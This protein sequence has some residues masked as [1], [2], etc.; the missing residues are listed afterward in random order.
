MKIAC[1]YISFPY[2]RL[3]HRITLLFVLLL[4]VGILAACPAGPPPVA[5]EPTDA[6]VAE[7]TATPETEGIACERSPLLATE[8]FGSRSEEADENQYVTFE[9]EIDSHREDGGQRTV[10]L[11]LHQSLVDEALLP[12]EICPLTREGEGFCAEQFQLGSEEVAQLRSLDGSPIVELFRFEIV[13][14]AAWDGVDPEGA[15]ESEVPAD[16]LANDFAEAPI[17]IWIEFYE[18]DLEIL[19]E[20]AADTGEIFSPLGE[21]YPGIGYWSCVDGE[22]AWKDFSNV[23]VIEEGEKSFL[24]VF[25]DSWN[26]PAVGMQP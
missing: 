14:F 9:Q 12:V 15:I 3:V 24:R 5:P 23:E 10:R 1:R 6:P 26:D 25:V 17:E 18:T 19:S 11:K 7:P 13:N 21:N 16:V 2:R 22:F 4:L 8:M 20:V